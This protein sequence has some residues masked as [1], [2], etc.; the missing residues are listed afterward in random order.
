MSPFIPRTYVSAT[1]PSLINLVYYRWG[2]MLA[3]HTVDFATAA[4][5][6]RRAGEFLWKN[7]PFLYEGIRGTI[8]SALQSTHDPDQIE[9]IAREFATNTL[10]GFL[11]AEFIH[12][13]L[14]RGT[15]RRH[16][17]CKNVERL[18]GTVRAGRGVVGVGGYFGNHQMGV[19]AFGHLLSGKVAGI[20][21]P[22]QYTTQQRW[23]AGMVRGGLARLYPAGDAIHNAF[24]ALR[25][26]RLVL[27]MGE[28]VSS[29]RNAVEATFLGAPHRFYPSAALMAWRARCPLAVVTCHRLDEPFQFEL[30]VR[31]WIEPLERGGKA[32]IRQATI[33]VARSLEA[34]ILERPAQYAWVNR[35]LLAGQPNG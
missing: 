34:S 16:V 33:R 23:M 6:A 31:D 12:R 21:S 15:W 28:H 18:A 4:R 3:A 17:R 5:V 9:T 32:W 27:I 24:Q 7:V 8:A 20:V 30:G 19:T 26:G 22:L 1:P 13:K 10:L 11:E 2:L 29:K 25:D 14:T 35:H